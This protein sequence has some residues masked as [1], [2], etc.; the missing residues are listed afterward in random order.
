MKTRLTG[1]E[2]RQEAKSLCLNDNCDIHQVNSYQ[3][4]TTTTTT[5]L[6]AALYTCYGVLVAR[7]FEL[8]EDPA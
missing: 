3:T 4:T 2:P 6:L 7:G 5:R 1:L 8:I